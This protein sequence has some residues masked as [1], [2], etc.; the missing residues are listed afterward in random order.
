MPNKK[1]VVASTA[2]PEN[3]NEKTQFYKKNKQI[4]DKSDRLKRRQEAEDGRADERRLAFLADIFRTLN[5]SFYAIA[6]RT[7]ISQQ[8]LSW[9]FSVK[10]DCR[11]SQAE[12]ILDAIGYTLSVELNAGQPPLKSNATTPITRISNGVKVN[13]VG[14]FANLTRL[15]GFKK[16]DFVSACQPTARMYWLAQYLQSINLPIMEMIARLDIDHASLKYI[17]A[18]DDIKISQIYRIA[19]GTNAEI[20]WKINIKDRKK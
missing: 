19:K 16:P 6:K 2:A 7:D 12:K 17:F 3:P 4:K 8:S 18:R 20:L 1:E 10:D 11:L 9:M 15:G 13:I 14:D 5:Y